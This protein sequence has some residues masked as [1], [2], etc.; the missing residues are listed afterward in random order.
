MFEKCSKAASSLS[1]KT[2][3]TDNVHGIRNADWRI[4]LFGDGHQPAIDPTNPDIIYSSSQKCRFYRHDRATGETLLIHGGS[5]GIGTT[6]I[7]LAK[8]FA[9]PSF[10][11]FEREYMPKLYF[12]CMAEYEKGLPVKVAFPPEIVETCLARVV[13]DAKLKQL[14]IQA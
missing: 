13:S 9:V 3:R 7:Q 4:T 14:Q 11:K 8:A 12:G 1:A 2:S 10:A 5:S 6:A